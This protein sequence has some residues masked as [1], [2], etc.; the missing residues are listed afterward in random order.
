MMRQD[1]YPIAKADYILVL[2]GANTAN[3]T[4][5]ILGKDIADRFRDS[6]LKIIAL[7]ASRPVTDAEKEKIRDFAPDAA[8]E[9]DAICAGM[10][11]VFG[12]GNGF[13]ETKDENGGIQRHWNDSD[14]DRDYYA[15]CTPSVNGR[16]ANTKDT[17]A[18]FLQLFQVKEKAEVVL[19]TTALYCNYQLFSLVPPALENKIHLT[20]AGRPVLPSTSL[21]AENF[22]QEIKATINAMFAWLSSETDS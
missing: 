9:Y 15:L 4:R 2:G 8:T 17:F 19:A 16:R 5:C 20:I 1:I 11:K 12:L 6:Q 13:I 3:E 21:H 22:L 18:H 7:G 14:K 10:E